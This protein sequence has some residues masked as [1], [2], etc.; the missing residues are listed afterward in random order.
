MILWLFIIYLFTN[1]WVNSQL[2]CLP[3]QIVFTAIANTTRTLIRWDGQSQSAGQGYF[4][5]KN[6]QIASIGAIFISTYHTK[7]LNPWP[8]PSA[9]RMV[10]YSQ[11]STCLGEME[12][13][14]AHP[15]SHGRLTSLRNKSQQK[16][17]VQHS[18]SV[19]ARI[20]N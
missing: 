17:P 3:F 12:P 15:S 9:N 19:P 20:F 8:N 5:T 10:N 11:L 13:F 6:N 16:Q 14:E 2:N 4:N 18:A 1:H 7:Q